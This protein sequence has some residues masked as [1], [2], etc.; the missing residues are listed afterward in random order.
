MDKRSFAY[1]RLLAAY[2]KLE[3]D[4]LVDKQIKQSE[5]TEEATRVTNAERFWTAMIQRPLQ[6]AALLETRTK[7]Y[8]NSLGQKNKGR[9]VFYAKLFT[10]LYNEIRAYEVDSMSGKKSANED[11]ILGYYYQQ[12]QFYTP[13]D[14]EK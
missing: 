8:R 6:T 4:A 3:E 9:S 10:Q 5:K 11:F 12:Q 13:K 1:G 7:Y 2:E 14:I